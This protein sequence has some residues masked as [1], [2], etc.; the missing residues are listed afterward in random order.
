VLISRRAL[1]TAAHCVCIE[2]S[3]TPINADSLLIYLGKYNLRKWTGPEQDGKVSEVI[4]HP[5]YDHSRF[6]SDIA[7]LRLKDDI[8][9][10]NH[11]RPVCLWN[12]NDDL[13]MI[14]DKLGEVPGWGYNEYGVVNEVLSSVKMPVVAHETCIWSNR[15]FFSRVTSDKSFCAGFRNCKWKL[16]PVIV[17]K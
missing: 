13:K 17:L 15:D 9:I 5:D 3:E 2:K 14:V 12:F 7:V 8:S 6:Y 11:V 4:V 16:V 1:L 10:D